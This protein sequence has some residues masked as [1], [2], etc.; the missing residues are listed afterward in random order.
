MKN[1]APQP[2]GWH[3][4][5]FSVKFGE[6]LAAQ[7]VRDG[8]L[9]VDPD[10]SVWRLKRFQANKFSQRILVSLPEP[11]R[12]DYGSKRGNRGFHVRD[13]EGPVSVCSHRLIWQLAY[14]DI[15]PRMTINHINGDPGDNR[16]ENLQLATHKEQHLHRYRVLGHRSAPKML[17]EFATRLAE[18]GRLALE[19]DVEPLRETLQAYDEYRASLGHMNRLKEARQ[20]KRKASR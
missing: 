5:P 4:G 10:G 15:P 8:I 9:R 20:A 13:A 11:K 17:K 3:G 2:K 14:G 1:D 16:L 19:G 18:T 7:M 6:R 12:I